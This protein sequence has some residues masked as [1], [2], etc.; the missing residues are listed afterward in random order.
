[1]FKI[2]DYVVYGSIGVC[3]ITDIRKDEYSNSDETEYYVLDPVYNNNNNMTIK[4]PVSNLKIPMRAVL[5]KDEVLS[6][7]ASMPEKETIWIEDNRQRIE[8]FNTILKSSKSEDWVTLVKTIHLEKEARS[9]E[10]KSLTKR[11]EDIMN[12][13]EKLLNE[14]FAV[15]LDISPDEVLPYII[16]HIS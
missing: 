2:N 9:V 16:E 4:I 5:T 10:G 7:I 15:A 8:Y 14:E 13:A 3:Q 6:L 11:D 12:M 1:M